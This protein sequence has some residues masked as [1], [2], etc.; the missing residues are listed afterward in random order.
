MPTDPLEPDRGNPPRTLYE[1]TRVEGH[2]VAGVERGRA[3]CVC[4][5]SQPLHDLLQPQVGTVRRE[6]TVGEIAK[7]RATARA[8]RDEHLRTTW[9]I[10]VPRLEG[11][12]V[13]D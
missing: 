13:E 12:T 11:E 4:G 8:W 7:V 10:L 5:E 6:L 1:W 3:R 2:E 9:P